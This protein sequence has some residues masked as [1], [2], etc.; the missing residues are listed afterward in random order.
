MA[1]PGAA[2]ALERVR[3]LCLALPEVTERPSHGA[4][5]W[6]VRKSPQF[7]IFHDDHHG[8]GR[9]GLWVAA[10]PGAQDGLVHASPENYYVPAYVGHRGWV[11]VRLDRG[12]PWDDVAAAIED[13][14][15]A[16]APPALAEEAVRRAGG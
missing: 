15:L 1:S 2:E 14:Y 11:G 6:F 13:A 16:V 10:P 7:A 4:P 3:A 12:L 8:D 5:S 9:L